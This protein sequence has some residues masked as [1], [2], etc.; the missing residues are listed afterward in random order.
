MNYHKWSLCKCALKRGRQLQLPVYQF[1]KA[2]LIRAFGE[3]W[4]TQLEEVAALLKEEAAGAGQ[5]EP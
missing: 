2:P 4:Y 5:S 1:L 3:E